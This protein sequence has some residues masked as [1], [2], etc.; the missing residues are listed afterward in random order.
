MQI[1][2]QMDGKFA[3]R[4]K[5]D[6]TPRELYTYRTIRCTYVMLINNS[7]CEAPI[8]LHSALLF[9]LAVWIICTYYRLLFVLVASVFLA[10][11]C[12]SY[13]LSS[14]WECCW[15]LLKFRCSFFT[16]TENELHISSLCVCKYHCSNTYPPSGVICQML[17][18]Q[19]IKL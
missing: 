10:A 1:D 4:G 7:F 6:R 16:P 9:A 17:N 15:I 8:R 5:H 13:L 14:E 11:G 3:A 2:C 19:K 12:V 18:F